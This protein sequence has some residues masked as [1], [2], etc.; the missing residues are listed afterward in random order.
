MTLNLV[1]PAG[2]IRFVVFDDR[3]QSPTKGC[4]NEFILSPGNY[5]RLTV[6][7][8]VWLAFQGLDEKNILLNIANL[9]HVP[10]ETERKMLP[11]ISYNW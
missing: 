3:A 5:A 4:F 9:E 2:K 1:V 10:E 11:E 7:P 6:P 8:K